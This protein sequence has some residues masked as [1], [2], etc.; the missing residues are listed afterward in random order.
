MK[1]TVSLLLALCLAALCALS[2]AESPASHGAPFA[3]PNMY[4]SFPE[5]PGPEENYIIYAN[6][7]AYVDAAAGVNPWNRDFVARAD[8]YLAAQIMDICRDTESTDAESEIIRIL[9]GLADPEKLERDG[10]APLTARAERL[11][12]TNT[13]EE[14]T[15]LIREDG[16][17]LSSPF[18][19]CQ[20]MPDEPVEWYRVCISK[21]VLIDDLP[22]SDEPTEEELMYGPKKDTESARQMLMNMQ[23]GEEEAER[24]VGEILR[25]DNDY[26]GE[27]PAFLD[28]QGEMVVSLREIREN[29]PLLLTL[30]E[31]A[32]LVGEAGDEKPA[33]IVTD[34]YGLGTFLA[35]YREENLETLKAIAAL[36]LYRDARLYLDEQ[37]YGEFRFPDAPG[38]TDA[39][40]LRKLKIAAEVPVNQAYINHYCPEEKWNAVQSLFGEI[41]QALRARLE[42][43][44]WLS[45]ASRAN[46]LAR[47]DDL[48]L[49][50]IIPPGGSFDCGPLLEQV[51]GCETLLDAAARCMRFSRRC[52]TRYIGERI[53]RD[54]VYTCSPGG[55]LQLSGAYL[56]YNNMFTIGAAAL[57]GSLCDTSSRETFLA[58]LGTHMAHE[59]S[60]GYDRQNIQKA[61]IITGEEYD[62][63][64][65]LSQPIADKLGRIDTGKGECLD[66]EWTC[67]ETMA[68]LVGCR[69]ILDLAEREEEFDYDLFFG[70]FAKLWFCYEKGEDYIQ[71]RDIHA[72]DYVRV[73]FTVAHFDEFYETY[74]TVTEGT[75]MY[76]A[77]EDRVTV[78]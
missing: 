16:F 27:P 45:D 58:T 57:G 56:A 77:P 20:A 42:K 21:A 40:A 67:C 60:H 54:N 69:L 43:S 46:C 71:V 24:L 33:Y 50:P 9:Y 31:C 51:R 22:M 63:F 78:Y 19:H 4:D 2:F 68:D 23:Y 30:L 11:K 59:I 66:G 7:D 44:A 73:N 37:R 35:W 61:G 10:L 1:K 32:G 76:I 52:M 65:K 12:A 17:M 5:R 74:P 62:A 49:Q 14:L 47:L 64:V 75:P 41:R 39:I 29:C 6:Y 36:S 53:E 72:P 25:Y 70:A 18:L 8:H 15:S 28:P 13:L 38:D 3:N 55:L 34:P 26:S 48:I